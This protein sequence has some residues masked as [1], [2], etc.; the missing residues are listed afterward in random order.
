MG[1]K[2]LIQQISHTF[3]AYTARNTALTEQSTLNNKL[4][5][6]SNWDTDKTV[7]DKVSE[8]SVSFTTN[9]YFFIYIKIIVQEHRDAVQSPDIREHYASGNSNLPRTRGAHFFTE[10]KKFRI[11]IFIRIFNIK[12]KLIS[13]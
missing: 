2:I 8:G 11:R 12:D 7:R 10:Q 4:P 6:P 1:S 3:G 13:F 5:F 9:A